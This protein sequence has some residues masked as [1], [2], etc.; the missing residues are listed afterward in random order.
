MALT[1]N[2]VI[3]SSLLGISYQAASPIKETGGPANVF[4]KYAVP[5]AT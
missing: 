3:V 2:S 4:P 1:L 5:L